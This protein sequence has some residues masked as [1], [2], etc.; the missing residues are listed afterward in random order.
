VS[1]RS[2]TRN[3]KTSCVFVIFAASWLKTRDLLSEQFL[4]I[5]G[6]AREGDLPAAN[7]ERLSDPEGLDL[8]R[9]LQRAQRARGPVARERSRGG[10]VDFDDRV[11]ALLDM[12]D[13]KPQ[14]GKAGHRHPRR[15]EVALGTLERAVVGTMLNDR[16]GRE[17]LGVLAEATFVE[18]L[19]VLPNHQMWV[20]HQMSRF[21]V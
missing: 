7:L 12:Q 14:I 16:V 10:H 2:T 13:L 18:C 1:S 20:G 4:K 15:F 17:Q 3:R 9:G 5:V 8:P 21:K 11:A 19:V 6:Q